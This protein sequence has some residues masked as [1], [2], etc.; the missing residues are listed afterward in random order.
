MTNIVHWKDIVAKNF[1]DIK[2]FEKIT[3]GMLYC[4]RSD[5]SIKEAFKGVSVEKQEAYDK[6]RW[7]MRHCGYELVGNVV[8]SHGWFTAYI[9]KDDLKFMTTARAPM[10]YITIPQYV[11]WQQSQG[12]DD[13]I[14]EYYQA[15]DLVNSVA[16]GM[17]EPHKRKDI[18]DD[19]EGGFLK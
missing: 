1:G 14:D 12:L 10:T 18:Y 5:Q 16:S 2:E 4:S 13:M 8:V 9:D 3:R 6:T 11:D 17:S 15:K 19:D 7:F